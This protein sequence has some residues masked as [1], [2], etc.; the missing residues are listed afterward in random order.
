MLAKTGSLSKQVVVL[1]SAFFVK[2]LL[3][4]ILNADSLLFGGF[5]EFE[6]YRVVAVHML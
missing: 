6:K 3:L 4:V 1:F 5:G 2:I